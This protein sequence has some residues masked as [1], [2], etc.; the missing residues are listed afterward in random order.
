MPVS[1]NVNTISF[2][3]MI[4]YFLPR[5]ITDKL[6]PAYE[7]MAIII[8]SLTGAIIAGVCVLV[9][10]YYYSAMQLEMYCSIAIAAGCL[11]TLFLVKYFGIYRTP[12]TIT[13]LFSMLP[14]ANLCI[15]TGGIFS[16][17]LTS[18]VTLLFIAFWV[19]GRACGVIMAAGNI[20]LL[21]TLCMYFTP[22]NELRFKVLYLQIAFTATI[23]VFCWFRL[24]RYEKLKALIKEQ[25]E[26]RVS[27][28]D[29]LVK[30]R[31]EELSE[32]RQNLALDFHDETGNML[33][34][35][36]RLSAM[37]KRRLT[38]QPEM[39]E[40]VDRIIHHSNHLYATSRDFLW[41]MND[42]SNNPYELF[43]YLTSFGQQYYNQFNISFEAIPA[44]TRTNGQA[45]LLPWFASRHIVF[46]FK[47][48]MTN[49]ARHSGA[50]H[51]AFE[52]EIN[53]NALNLWLQDNGTWKAPSD[54]ARSYG[55]LN[56]EKRS[57]KNGF[58]YSI[59]SSETGTRVALS[60]PLSINK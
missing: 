35:I 9:P 33:S 45:P 8:G 49:A 42:N 34:A 37:L 19:L 29:R 3:R 50:T 1:F 12:A 11:I 27:T 56:M 40:I 15:Q 28:L 22:E 18:T 17:M 20:I 23:S 51:I 24:S 25:Q 48:A 26:I 13:L 59:Y 43:D 55:M 16:P 5:N 2:D 32:L 53:D 7:Q 60:V 30:E 6:H 47:E 4:K 57:S 44:V 10:F 38:G 52:M 54:T 46:I 14:I 41:G 36:S 31:T 58:R 39:T 21:Y